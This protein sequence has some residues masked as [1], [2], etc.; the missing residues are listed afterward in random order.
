MKSCNLCIQYAEASYSCSIS[1]QTPTQ[2][3]QL[4]PMYGSIFICQWHTALNTVTGAAPSMQV[5]GERF[6]VHS[7][8]TAGSEVDSVLESVMTNQCR[9]F[10]LSFKAVLSVL[11]CDGQS[12]LEQ[13]HHKE[14]LPAVMLLMEV[15]NHLMILRHLSCGSNSLHGYHVTVILREHLPIEGNSSVSAKS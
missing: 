14:L 4:I 9:L 6:L 7:C 2:N 11:F 13:I 10:F 3:H 5:I 15:H 1:C 12:S 8:C